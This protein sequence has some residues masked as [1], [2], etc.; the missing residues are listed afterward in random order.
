MLRAIRPDHWPRT[1][2]DSRVKTEL[3]MWEI[4]ENLHRGDLTV[5]ER[6]LHINEWIILPKELRRKGVQVA[7]PVTS[8]HHLGQ[9]AQ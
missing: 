6:A 8:R 1:I 3:R 7:H 5:L 9:P 2:D 4:A